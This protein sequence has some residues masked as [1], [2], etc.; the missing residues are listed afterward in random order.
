MRVFRY[1]D[2][3]HAR[4]NTGCRGW[5]G[6]RGRWGGAFVSLFI[7]T[8]VLQSRRPDILEDQVVGVGVDGV[9]WLLETINVTRPHNHP[10][11]H[12]PL[13]K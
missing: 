1:S 5:M 8:R 7:D 9:G 6:S 11:I 3:P 13:T 12:R 10:Q 4:V 2:S